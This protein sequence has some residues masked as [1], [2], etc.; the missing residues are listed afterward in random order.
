M[1]C[2]NCYIETHGAGNV[3]ERGRWP[4]VA[5]TSGGDEGRLG[6]D[7]VGGATA[8]VAVMTSRAALRKGLACRDGQFAFVG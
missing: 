7:A 5:E 8:E 6:A 2:N 1:Q 4:G 3:N